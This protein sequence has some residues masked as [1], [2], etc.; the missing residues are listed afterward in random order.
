MLYFFLYPLREYFFGF[1]VFR[2]ITFRAAGAGT[3]AF[4]LSVL[5]G[6]VVI[7][8]LELLGIGQTVRTEGHP[9]FKELHH[10]KEG[11]PTMGGLF[12]VFSIVFSV[13]LWADLSNRFILVMLLVTLWLTFVGFIDDAIKLWRG[14]AKGMTIAM[15]LS[16]QLILAIALSVWVMV[17]SGL[18]THLELPFFKEAMIDLSF[19]YLPFVVLVI[20]GSSNAVNLTDGLDGLA[21]GCIAIA[22]FAYSILSYIAGH[23]EFSSYLHISYVAESGEL[24]VF[25]IAVAG[26]ALGFLWF[27]SYPAAVFMGDTG[28]LAL[29]GILGA[30]AIFIKKELLLLIIGGI[31][32]AEA[33]STLAQIISFRMFKKRIFLMA[34]LHHHFQLKGWPENKV[35][36]R[37]WI[38]AVILAVTGIATLKLR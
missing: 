26:A 4:L 27:N 24:A 28:A 9:K 29:G 19:L 16:G 25:C 22:A 36:V 30:T 34:P 10:G 11:V 1:N 8:R 17:D 21:A 6:P 33:A 35:T 5:F 20:I 18:S 23:A 3:T 37:F 32:V 2:Y 13:L 14:D 12:V 38:I 15:K 7:Q 31:F